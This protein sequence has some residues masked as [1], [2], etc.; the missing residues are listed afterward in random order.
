[1]DVVDDTLDCP[2]VPGAELESV[3]ERLPNV[4][5]VDDPLDDP[6]VPPPGPFES[7]GKILPKSKFTVYVW[8]EKLAT[9]DDRLRWSHVNNLG[10]LIPFGLAGKKISSNT[11]AFKLPCKVQK[12]ASGEISEVLRDGYL[13]EIEGMSMAE[14]WQLRTTNRLG[15]AGLQKQPRDKDTGQPTVPSGCL[16]GRRVYFVC[17]QVAILRDF[18]DWWL[19]PNN[20]ELEKYPAWPSLKAKEDVKLPLTELLEATW[21]APKGHP[22]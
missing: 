11:I 19:D 12:R 18:T 3:R 20:T 7:V 8:I 16:A 2:V 17:D 10:T 14:A 21:A 22:S 13:T 15:V 4:E 6:V 5:L 9:D 1:M